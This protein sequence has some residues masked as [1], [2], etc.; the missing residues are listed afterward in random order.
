MGFAFGTLSLMNRLVTIAILAVGAVALC[1]CNEG[2]QDLPKQGDDALRN[3]LSR[4]LTPE[5]LSKMGG[6]GADGSGAK[7]AGRP[8]RTTG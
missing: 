6:G 7:S 4:P 3:N 2:T 8:A 5:E 1:G